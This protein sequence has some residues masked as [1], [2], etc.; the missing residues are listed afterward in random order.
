M[1]VLWNALWILSS[2]SRPTEYTNPHSLHL[3]QVKSFWP[4]S[5]KYWARRFFPEALAELEIER[6]SC[7]CG[8]RPVLVES[9]FKLFCTFES[10]SSTSEDLKSASFLKG[11]GVSHPTLREI[12]EKRISNARCAPPLAD[13]QA[14]HQLCFSSS[15]DFRS[16]SKLPT[17]SATSSARSSIIRD[18]ITHAGHHLTPVFVRRLY[19]IKTS[20]P[21]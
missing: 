21:E 11:S 20:F 8:G 16:G 1:Y 3:L 10:F 9:G 6:F 4:K 13:H 12:G 17:V 7:F 19:T 14:S 18:T 15:N 5:R 2:S